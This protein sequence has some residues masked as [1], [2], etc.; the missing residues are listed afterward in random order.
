MKRDLLE[1]EI[2]ELL[3]CLEPDLD[4]IQL[5]RWNWVWH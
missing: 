5:M 3:L 1:R 2:K 4:W